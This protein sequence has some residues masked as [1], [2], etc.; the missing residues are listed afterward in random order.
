[1]TSDRLGK[2]LARLTSSNVKHV[3]DTLVDI[4][5][6][7]I[8]LPNG[9][10]KLVTG[11]VCPKLLHLI[12]PEH[13]TDDK[14]RD[15]VLSIL[16][17]IC[18]EEV[19]RVEVQKSG[20]IPIIAEVLCTSE[21]ESIQ[22]RC[23][24]TLANLALLRSNLDPL[25][26]TEA[27][28]KIVELLQSTKTPD[29]Q[30][31]YCRAIRI[32]GQTKPC[33]QQL[34]THS[35]I[36][37]LAK[38][39]V[40]TE[41]PEVQT[42][43]LRALAELAPVGC[44]P[45]FAAQVVSSGATSWLLEMVKNVESSYFQQSFTLVF[46]LAEHSNF[47]PPFGAAGG[48][49]SF[50]ELLD[51]E[52]YA[53]YRTKMLN[54]LCLCCKDAVNRVRLREAGALQLFLRVAQ[55]EAF[56]NLY[57]RMISS[58]LC[59]LYDDQSFQVLLL[60]GLVPCLLSQLQ[61]C[62]GFVSTVHKHDHD[63]FGETVSQSDDIQTER[64][65]EDISLDEQK[66]A[67]IKEKDVFIFEESFPVPLTG[68]SSIESNSNL[69]QKAK[70]DGENE[71]ISV[72]GG[73]QEGTELVVGYP[74]P[75]EEIEDYVEVLRERDEDPL[76]LD[77]RS[78]KQKTN[79]VE[80]NTEE[81]TA[82]KDDNN[83]LY[84]SSSRPVFSIDSPTYQPDTEWDPAEYSSGIK[85]KQ[86]FSPP[87][88]YGRSPA[89]AS[90]P[91]AMSPSFGPYSPLSNNSYYSPTQ[92]SPD[93]SHSD[94]EE[95]G[96]STDHQALLPNYFELLQRPDN[97]DSRS[98]QCPAESYLSSQ[99]SSIEFKLHCSSEKDKDESSFLEQVNRQD[100]TVTENF[101]ISAAESEKTYRNKSE[102]QGRDICIDEQNLSTLNQIN[103]DVEMSTERVSG[104]S[105]N[106]K[107]YSER[108]T[109]GMDNPQDIDLVASDTD[110]IQGV[111]KDEL[112]RVTGSFLNM[113][114]FS[115][116]SRVDGESSA[117]FSHIKRTAMELSPVLSPVLSSPP[118][119]KSRTVDRAKSDRT[120]ENNILMLMSRIS[121]AL[122]MT[123]YLVTEKS[124]SCI[125]DYL[126]F[127]VYPLPRM[128]RLFV[129]VLQNPHMLQKILKL[130][131]PILIHEQLLIDENEKDMFNSHDICSIDATVK[132]RF[133]EKSFSRSSSLS[134]LSS[135]FEDMPTHGERTSHGHHKEAPGTSRG[136]CVRVGQ[137][138]A[139]VEDSGVIRRESSAMVEESGAWVGLRLIQE[140]SY[141]VD[142]HYSR[143]EVANLFHRG[144]PQEK[145]LVELSMPFIIRTSG[146]CQ[147][148]LSGLG[149]LNQ[150]LSVLED[151][152][153]MSPKLITLVID[154]LCF[155]AK[156]LCL[157][158][159]IE[160]RYSESVV[161][162]TEDSPGY[163]E[164]HSEVAVSSCCDDEIN[165]ANHGCQLSQHRNQ[166]VKFSV[167]GQAVSA[168]RSVLIKKSD[169][170]AA[171][172]TGKYSE[173]GQSEIHIRET[174][175]CAFQYLIH[176]LH[177]C[178]INSCAIR[179]DIEVCEIS[180][181]SVR[182]VL[183]MLSLADR[184]LMSDLHKYLLD[185]L[186]GR[187]LV[188]NHCHAVFRHAVVHDIEF[189]R[190]AAVVGLMVDSTSRSDRL[191]LFSKFLSDS[192]S[193]VFLQTIETLL[194]AK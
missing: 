94:N 18:M 124:I 68:L 191:Q 136:S 141:V 152:A 89:S 83:A 103:K 39:L 55:D 148:Y 44:T 1:M 194:L 113:S 9:V 27:P 174:S 102:K 169:I 146:S 190:E 100:D 153:S 175:H 42:A 137:N 65:K 8:K 101:T 46:H 37:A 91:Q 97:P 49:Q 93:N 64:N 178:D 104:A 144:T 167:N 98:A 57:D 122:G 176:Y 116:L 120:T 2:Y 127:T 193:P 143:G 61:R 60:N 63:I 188:P 184:Y 160:A 87:D 73:M 7:L 17:N 159:I 5:T 24:R 142:S 115:D 34:V 30:Q 85:C 66:N 50:M 84:E 156:S 92:S 41:T 31:T 48:I 170:F 74:E 129:R 128:E 80:Q 45:L 138:S 52:H 10:T 117:Q 77:D 19:A 14:T 71:E 21:Q 132:S 130:Q 95:P 96:P 171:M 139:W 70:Y 35:A 134:S 112:S 163:K 110:S 173:S 36:F 140:L 111:C 186:I 106:E 6:R 157:R 145:R 26:K 76:K 177:D 58:W 114:R 182:H 59:F 135:D 54:C 183:D 82:N 158:K 131:V 12:N 125:V 67:D 162:A 180:E 151:R 62:V 32:L 161:S 90:P 53:L 164:D 29:Y 119:K 33:L 86:S 149:I 22:N 72:K 181:T 75:A 155:L 47:R 107:M 105:E 40:T 38:L 78:L 189:L 154:G 28:A 25:H 109:T 81:D 172:L 166:D 123:K 15:L 108:K 99:V 23:G 16:G 168:V 133:R 88:L 69:G 4:R 79:S 43:A 147:F 126:K 56:S 187:F 185:I 13:D 11:G 179:R 165:L 150:L 118:H 121:Q 51:S 3:Y 20:G 192:F